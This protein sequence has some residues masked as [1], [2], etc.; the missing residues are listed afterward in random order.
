MDIHHLIF[1]TAHSVSET[2]M[3][4]LIHHSACLYNRSQQDALFHNFIF[5][6]QLYIFCT[7]LLTIEE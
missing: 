1:Y 4:L 3:A 2:G 5:D 7:D 6:I